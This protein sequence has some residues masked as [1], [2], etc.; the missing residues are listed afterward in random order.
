MAKKPFD[1]DDIFD[2]EIGD[3]EE[4]IT[5]EGDD[6]ADEEEFDRSDSGE[7]DEEDNEDAADNSGDDEEEDNEAPK[8]PAK[9]KPG[10][11]PKKKAG[12]TAK[13]RGPGRPRKEDQKNDDKEIVTF[14]NEDD[15]EDN[16]ETHDIQRTPTKDNKEKAEGPKRRLPIET[17]DDEDD[18]EKFID[19]AEDLPFRADYIEHDPEEDRKINRYRLDEEAEKQAATY[20][21][22][23]DRLAEAKSNRD[24]QKANLEY[25]EAKVGLQMRENPPENI[26]VTDSTISN[27][28]SCNDD[29]QSA[30]NK[31]LEEQA[32][33]NKLEAIV[34][35]MEH[36]RSQIKNLTMLWIGGYYSVPGSSREDEQSS[37]V[38]EAMRDKL[39][40]R[41]RDRF[42][43]DE[44][45]ED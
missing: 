1:D 14:E 9:R 5:E 38:S 43:E 29:V 32:L 35:A 40:E 3:E 44:E 17:E 8:Q 26:K 11:P 24:S 31:Y 37:R 39:K 33:V 2:D 15:D 22:Y 36:R 16:T 34:T 12:T 10:R 21:F 18:E 28:V 27:L 30:K 23:A 20:G 45:Q 19:N 6:D 7:D 4:E 13:K 25:I 41:S 42:E